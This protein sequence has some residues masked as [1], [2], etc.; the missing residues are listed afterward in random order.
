MPL[1]PEWRACNTNPSEISPLNQ[2]A[3]R[4]WSGY[5][6]A[7]VT[8]K[9][10]IH[11]WTELPSVREF[12][13]LGTEKHPLARL[14]VPHDRT[15][16][17]GSYNRYTSI[18]E[19]HRNEITLCSLWALKCLIR[20]WNYYSHRLFG[21]KPFPACSV[22]TIICL[23]SPFQRCNKITEAVCEWYAEMRAEPK[24]YSE[25]RLVNDPAKSHR[26]LLHID[27]S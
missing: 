9:R 20:A 26:Y 1:S 3:W 19:E 16:S 27:Y 12:P 18:L 7:L 6:Y 14:T 2:N 25:H 23:S 22:R 21:T 13:Q 10:C 11:L 17:C 15:R 8:P 24:C 5:P 4:R